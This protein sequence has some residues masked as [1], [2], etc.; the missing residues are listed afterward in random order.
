MAQVL[1]K[2]YTCYNCKKPILISKIDNPAPGSKKRWDQ[3]EL[4]SITPHQCKKQGQDERQEPIPK[5][6]Q[7]TADNGPSQI[8]ELSKQVKDLK[9]IVNTLIAQIQMLRSEVKKSKHINE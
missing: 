4:D 2:E 1:S 9:D 8:A 3:W 5:P 7:Q 6:H